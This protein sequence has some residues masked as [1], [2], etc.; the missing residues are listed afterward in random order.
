[1]IAMYILRCADGS[2]YTGST[3]DL[4]LRV[5]QH[6]AGTYP[7]GYTAT[8]RPVELVYFEE[9]DRIDDAWARERQVHNWTRVK[10]QA[11][12]DGRVS[13]LRSASRRPRARLTVDFETRRLRRR[14]SAS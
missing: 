11:L 3:R 14:S 12:I 4:E 13:E 9:Y 5:E 1:M 6:Q 2:F 10:K 7:D 8:R